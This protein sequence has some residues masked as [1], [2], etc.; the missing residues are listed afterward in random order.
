LICWRLFFSIWLL[1]L[2]LGITPAAYADPISITIASILGAVGITVSASAITAAIVT[3]VIGSVVSFGISALVGAISKPKT[4]S[5][6]SFAAD[7][8]SRVQI[9]R[10]AVESHKI[11]YGRVRVSGPMVYVGSTNKGSSKNAYLHMAIALAAHECAEIEA[12]YIN[13]ETVTLNADGFVTTAKYLHK[14]APKI[15]IKTH[16]GASDQIADPLMV[17]EIP[18]WTQDHRLRGITYMY[19]RL[20]YQPQTFP[21][22]VPQFSAIVK[23]KKLYDPRDGSTAYSVNPALCIRDYLTSPTYGRA[24]TDAEID[25]PSF[26]ASANNCDELVH[27]ADGSTQKRYTCNGVVDTANQPIDILKDLCTSMAG[28]L[29]YVQGRFRCFSG[30]YSPPSVTIDTS[31]LAGDVKIQAKKPLNE[32]FNAVKGVFADP[33]SN[34]QPNDFPLVFNTTYQTQD[35]GSQIVRDLELPFT[36]DVVEAQRIAKIALEQGRQGILVTVPCNFKALQLSIYDTVYVNLAQVGW[37]SKVFRVTQ[38]ALN[39]DGGFTLTLQEEASQSYDWNNGEQTIIDPAPDTNLPDLF[40]CEPPGNPVITE[41]LY[42][43]TDGSGV[44]TRALITWTESVHTFVD[45][46]IIDYKLSTDTDFTPAG[47]VPY[48]TTTLTIND[49]APGLYDFRVQAVNVRGVDSD[50]AI[51]TQEIYGLTKPPADITGFT[52]MAISNQAHLAWDQVADLDVRIGGYIRLR[53]SNKITGATWSEGIDIGDALPGIATT[54]VVP[55]LTGTYMIKAYD[56]TRV[57]SENATFIV[58]D[59]VN[60][61]NLN[62]IAVSSQHPTFAGTKTNMLVSDSALTLDGGSLFDDISGSDAADISLLTE[63]GQKLITEDGEPISIET[64]EVLL[65]ED[66]EALLTEDG[67][68]LALETDG[69]LFDDE[70]G[71]FDL[72]GGA[73]FATSGEYIFDTYLDTGA[74][75]KAR[76]YLSIDA[77]VFD[78]SENFDSATGDFD[79][80]E[81]LF[82]GADRANTVV[83]A[84][85]KTTTADPSTATDPT[86][87]DDPIWSEWR[88]FVVG[89]FNARAYWCKITIE[90]PTHSNNILISEL[91]LNVDVPDREE[92]F[93]DAVLSAGGTSLTYDKPFFGKP[94]FGITIQGTVSGD[95]PKYTHIT[96]GGKYTGVTVQ[97]LNGGSGVSRSVDV[98]A[99]AY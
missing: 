1:L 27:L 43:T 66:G 49:M 86:N 38:W 78:A 61:I 44:K 65:A 8:G 63:D 41:E 98:V 13:D 50:Y 84:W 80:R 57:E 51:T 22:G 88:K 89:D 74:I 52:M 28:V 19:I 20:E 96:S 69:P 21:D 40:T 45:K 71:D 92:H 17:A 36:T 58:T 91:A 7:L 76:A 2:F 5:I 95:T 25:D 60:I 47:T 33:A 35:G 79:S 75:Y 87:P 37:S 72:G 12:I 56:S 32:L 29:P 83:T 77:E 93:E 82:S 24:A 3:A 10:S 9:S 46:Y 59:T 16:L 62:S 64:D 54:A 81:G 42:T 4:P 94:Q 11:I 23:G 30:Y 97:I 15:R 14:G 73:G 70:P 67:D 39:V 6:S 31:W 26:I 34:W 85:I 99:K 90:N 68:P 48:S 53:W 18:G 55:L